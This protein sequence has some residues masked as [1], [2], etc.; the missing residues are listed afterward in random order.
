MAA[1]F[2]TFSSLYPVSSKTRC[3]YN[4]GK[5]SLLSMLR[6]MSYRRHGVQILCLLCRSITITILFR[7]HR[8]S[9]SL[10]LYIAHF[11]STIYSQLPLRLNLFSRRVRYQR[12]NLICSSTLLS[13]I[14]C[15]IVIWFYMRS[16]SLIM[17]GNL[18]SIYYYY[19]YT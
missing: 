10:G 11:R 4:R 2:I 8:R 14:N 7:T 18:L 1:N 12:W 15:V 16:R 5:L 3:P 13:P 17:R 9:D 6:A 19:Y